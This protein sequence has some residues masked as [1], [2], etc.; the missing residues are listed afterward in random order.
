M[1]CRLRAVVTVQNPFVTGDCR[2]YVIISNG[3]HSFHGQEY[4]VEVVTT[5]ERDEAVPLIETAFTEWSLRRPSFVSSW[6]PVTSKAHL[7]NEHLAPVTDYATDNIVSNLSTY[8]GK[9]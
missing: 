5:T 6:S 1:G 4:I 8:L 2:P 7:I 3:Q 9:P